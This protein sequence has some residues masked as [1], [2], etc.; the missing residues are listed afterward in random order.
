M[1]WVKA[2]LNRQIIS[3]LVISMVV[4]AILIMASENYLASQSQYY[5]AKIESEFQNAKRVADLQNE[6]KVQVQEWKNVLIRGGNPSDLE[7]YWDRFKSAEGNVR[8]KVINIQE[9]D[10]ENTYGRAL[11]QFSQAHENM[12]VAYRT[13]YRKFVS[14]GFD[15][16][17][18]DNAVRGIDRQPS[19]LISELLQSS[20]KHIAEL[21]EEQKSAMI[22]VELFSFVLIT[23]FMIL[24]TLAIIFI[25]NRIIVSPISRLV[26]EVQLFGEGGDAD[27][28]CVRDDEVGLLSK[29][30]DSMKTAREERQ[31]EIQRQASVNEGIKMALDKCQANVMFANT[32]LEI[33]YVNES[34]VDMLTQRESQLRTVLPNLSVANIVG[35]NVSDL[36]ENPDQQR[37][38]LNN[39]NS[40]FDTRLKI[41]GLTFD[42]TS[43][44]VISSEGTRLG[45]VVEWNDITDFL[46]QEER[47][48]AIA[49]ENAGIKMALDKCQANVMFANTDLEITYLN[50]SVKGMLSGREDDLRSV[51]PNFSVDDLMGTCVDD[52]HKKP[53]HQRG[54]LADLKEPYNTR[55]KL[56]GLTF[57]LIASPVIDDDG[58]RL[59][60]VVEWN[61]ITE[62]LAKREREEAVAQE[63]L[64]V[65]QAL[66]S[67]SANTMVA[68]GD[69]N[70]VYANDAV[71]GMLK[72]AEDDVRKALPNF[73]VDTVLGSN[74]DGFHANPAH[75]RNL[76]GGLKNTYKTQIEVAGRTF[77]L[78][79]NP[80]FND[81]DTRIGTVVE[82]NDRTEEVKA[83]GEIRN[84]INAAANGDLA[85]RLETDG[86]EGFFRVISEGLNE[87]VS[88]AEGVI[89]DVA[90]VLDAMSHGN[91][92]EV[93]DKDYQGI[94]DKLKRDA[95]QT[96][97]KLSEIIGQIRQSSVNVSSAADEIAQG[98]ADLSQRTE[99]QASS[100]E[101]TA[102]SME[103]MTSA[104]KQSADN[105]ME[106]SRLAD[107]AR[108]KAQEGG[109][110]VSN[111]VSAMEEINVASKK[112]S[113]IIGVIDE[114][115][116][117]T[118]L[119]ALNAAVEAARAGEQG[120]GFAVV[121]G[122]V[123]NLAQRSAGAAK[124]IKDLIRDS[125]SKVE[126]GT[127]LVNESG[128]TL[129]EIVSAV[130][131][132]TAMVSDISSAAQE[133]TS[134][135]DQVNNAVNQMDEM[136]QQN[137][138]LVEEASAAAEAMAEQSRKMS[139]LV[140][141]FNLLEESQ[142][143]TVM[144]APSVQK[145]ISAPI[146]Q[147]APVQ[148]AMSVST[149][150]S[151]KVNG[152]GS[153]EGIAVTSDDDQWD[154]F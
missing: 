111:A 148:K 112:I 151:R 154:E 116:F 145:Q 46:A 75:Q 11:K 48:R 87:L 105:A 146:Q 29:T 37:S 90:R 106:A 32:D 121:A 123:R 76:L 20:D 44:P 137:A 74:F 131:R 153:P 122:E 152:G 56:A 99:E 58:T 64:R 147:T 128:N 139:N 140:G 62:S 3:V 27:F 125:V 57:D 133:Q 97:E 134:G 109:D 135:I 120:R 100:L 78:I 39:L 47:E 14:S 69:G 61:D 24:I 80:I 98:N 73:S 91:L 40:P 104:V 127:A 28:S 88:I 102:S 7:K 149:Q 84:L 10:T 81:D 144:V 82:W 17:Q 33:T 52:F 42:V 77:S 6:F 124:E 107:D 142:M 45:I 132:V 70:I 63:N 72:N 93:I 67:V 103:E 30:L 115:A 96:T 38:N 108:I 101:E 92:T 141:F 4:L 5:S 31:R 143:G 2:S 94:Y 150:P 59:G 43:T 12:G 16:S 130:D 21:I 86:K 66:D 136:T 113:D 89:N 119:L 55:L 60:T 22:Q 9:K 68:D 13:G 79:A 126:D 129:S 41:A 53:A 118:N 138:A 15:V 8:K 95:N 85:I 36:H 114:I 54:L 1:N 34:V 117:Q 65:R 50:D 83:E 71:L 49:R 23:L 25:V 26:S 19:E 18:A 51:L 35:S 110:V